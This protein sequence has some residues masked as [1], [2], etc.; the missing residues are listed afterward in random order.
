MKIDRPHNI[1][2]TALGAGMLA[3]ILMLLLH[4][5]VLSGIGSIEILWPMWVLAGGIGFPLFGF[6]MSRAFASKI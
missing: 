2:S 1:E 3:G 6:G 4:V 5:I